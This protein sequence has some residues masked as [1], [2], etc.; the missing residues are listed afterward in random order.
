[1]YDDFRSMRENISEPSAVATHPS[2][3]A[4][5]IGTGTGEVECY[6]FED[7]MF[8]SAEEFRD[9]NPAWNEYF[10]PEESGEDDI[11]AVAY[12]VGGAHVVCVN[13]SGSLMV[14]DSETGQQVHHTPEVA[15]SFHALACINQSIFATGDDGGV[16]Q[17]WDERSGLDT[18]QPVH[19]LNAHSDYISCLA[20]KQQDNSLVATSGDGT[21]AVFDLRKACLRQQ[22]DPDEDELLS[23]V[24]V[25]RGQKVVAGSQEGVL[26][27]FSW[28]HF[29]DCS[30]RFPGHPE[31]IDCIVKYDE[32]TVITGGGDGGI[33]V[34]SVHPNKLLGVVGFAEDEQV[35]DMALSADRRTLITVTDDSNRLLI[36]DVE[37][38]LEEDDEDQ[39]DDEKEEDEED[40]GD[41]NS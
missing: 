29:E 2:E 18:R 35:K 9:L 8:A 4:M 11:R 14:I 21:L 20:V 1:M 7:H 16:V 25:K 30:D 19:T 26:S 28:G 12:T 36:W 32:D 40:D 24:V 13:A 22:S 31:T 27:I 33:R 15:E 5:C 41:G 6:T 38:L 23:C 10:E 34:L 17:I 39:D 3:N 37:P